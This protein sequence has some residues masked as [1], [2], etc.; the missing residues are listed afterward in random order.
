MLDYLLV[1]LIA[2]VSRFRAV[3]FGEFLFQGWALQSLFEALLE[4]LSDWFGNTRRSADGDVR[5]LLNFISQFKKGWDTGT[6]KPPFTNSR[7]EQLEFSRPDRLGR[8]IG[9][10]NPAG[11]VKPKD[12]SFRV[13]I[14]IH[15]NVSLVEHEFFSYLLPDHAVGGVKTHC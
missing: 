14:F 13:A 15:S 9:K 1:F 3:L 8:G 11:L 6:T 2:Y 4:F 12:P 5:K 7:Y 10:N